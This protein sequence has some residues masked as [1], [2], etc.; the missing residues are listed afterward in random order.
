[1]ASTSARNLP[2]PTHSQK[3]PAINPDLVAADVRR[4]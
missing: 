3:R 2:R 1:L 4:L